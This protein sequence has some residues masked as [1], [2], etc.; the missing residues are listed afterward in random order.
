MSLFLKPFGEALTEALQPLKQA[1][2]DPDEMEIFLLELGWKIDLDNTTID[3]VANG[4]LQLTDLID[5]ATGLFDDVKHS[6]ADPQQQLQDVIALTE[7]IKDFFETIKTYDASTTPNIPPPL[8]N[9]DFWDAIRDTLPP[10]LIARYLEKRQPF[11]YGSFLFIGV[12]EITDEVPS[13]P[14]ASYK[15]NYKK[16]TID[17]SRLGEFLADPAELLKELY[18]WNHPSA[19]FDHHKLLL[20]LE[21]FALA[22]KLMVTREVPPRHLY[23]NSGYFT[24]QQVETQQIEALS[25]PV[26]T[27]Q[28][29][30]DSG[31]IEVGAI[32]MPI[33]APSGSVPDGL[34]LG[35][36][37]TAGLNST[38]P[39]T[40]ELTLTLSGEFDG[41]GTFG[42]KIFPDGANLDTTV[43]NG[44]ILADLKL[45][46]KPQDAETPWILLGAT[47]QTRLEVEGFEANLGVH[48]V[49][50]DL[51][52]IL[53][54]GTGENAML[55]FVFQPG[56]GDSFIQKFFAGNPVKIEWS[57]MAQWS[58]KSGFG[59]QGHLG[60]EI[61]IP[62]HKQIG[63]L[64]LD[65]LVA[66]LGKRDDDSAFTLGINP[67]LQLGPIGLVINNIGAEFNVIKKAP[68]ESSGILGNIDLDFGFKPPEG[69]GLSVDANGIIKG[70]GFLSFDKD[71]ARYEGALELDIQNVI[72]IKAIG[73]L[74]T[75]LP[76]GEEGYSLLLL[77]RTDFQPIQLGFGFTLNG[78]GGLIA[79]NR[80][81]N[82]EALREG[83]RSNEL[84]DILSLKDPVANID[85]IISSLETMFPIQ[86]DRYA[87]GPTAT[88][89]WGTP[90]L[91]TVDVGLFIGLPD[92]IE[93]AIVGVIR[94]LLP[95]ENTP[96]LQLQVNFSGTISFAEKFI[97]FD[98]SLFDSKLLSMTLS[99]NM[100]FR[101]RYGD[102][103]TFVL[104]VGGF[105]PDFP[106][107]ALSLP[108]L[109]RITVNLLD[110]DNP[111]LTLSAYFA[112]TSNTAQFGAGAEFYLGLTDKLEVS[113]KL[114]FDTLFQFS[115][116]YFTC[117][118]AGNIGVFR[119][120]KSI[121]SLW[122]AGA[123]EGPAPW[124]FQGTVEFSALGLTYSKSI[125]KT[126]GEEETT[127]LPDYAVLNDLVPALQ[128]KKN[129][130][131]ELPSNVPLLVTVRKLPDEPGKVVVH[132]QGTMAVNQ[133]VVPLDLAIERFGNQ[134]PANGVN[135]FSIKLADSANQEYAKYDLE[136]Y[137]AP[138][139]FFE[140]SDTD[141]LSQPSFEKYNSGV[142]VS[143]SGNTLKS[144]GFR[145]RELRYE[146]IYM[147]SRYRP[148]NWLQHIPSIAQSNAFLSHT[149]A[150]GS[151][152][153]SSSRSGSLFAPLK[154]KVSGTNYAVA[155]T[156]NLA[157]YNNI[158]A[159]TAAEAQMLLDE[160]LDEQPALEGKL[161]VVH[162]FELA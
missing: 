106:V 68:N 49:L 121:V 137:F 146:Q 155:Q 63:P 11:F 101:L 70:G 41:T 16:Y 25:V 132:P 120:D 3:Y 54:L 20:H 44:L 114:S 87:F 133:K 28:P 124:R 109:D 98:A 158:T 80:S 43:N 29:V 110:G 89:G 103:P 135:F 86:A 46:G 116:F 57:G 36:I 105:H 9:S 26:I 1:V 125:D 145:E 99:G 162:A 10:Y 138:A 129:W 45:E 55:R 18:N 148:A 35:P 4:F 111:R 78:V 48:G 51:E 150:A 85:S 127:T 115:P 76:G 93:I 113:G 19:P 56:E 58:S 82:L 77:I 161:R 53:S 38:I 134:R 2:S 123:L 37:A 96:L 17:I 153:G 139:Q 33:P 100:A 94:A 61:N 31:Y 92:P 90:T 118:I 119:N 21:Q 97:T 39:L 7:K 84:Y 27:G 117:T 141:K 147:D 108:S 157:L 128:E 74:T 79:L 75:K 40:P 42:V 50:D 69:V 91:I 144:G 95:D 6:T 136:E 160:L 73:I 62:I 23:I 122:F 102:N 104:S 59:I 52:V 131:T 142:K 151:P 67:S 12:V 64:L 32:L 156:H 81:M 47:E 107:P 143:L 149:A 83:V 152:M 130:Q 5:D 22:L 65:S 24:D 34:F 154:V 140:F 66:K 72:A 88:I 30:N 13:G 14:L 8:N 15:V 71:E 126:F 60:F 159:G 112:V